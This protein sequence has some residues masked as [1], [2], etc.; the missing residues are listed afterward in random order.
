VSLIKYAAANKREAHRLLADVD[1]LGKKF[2]VPERRLWHIKVKAFAENGEWANLRSL[3]ESKTK[4]PIGFRP[5][6]RAAIKGKLG[7]AEVTRYIE[8]V[9]VPEE[10]YDLF[11]EAELWK[12]ALDEAVKMR[13]AQ[14]VANVRSLCNSEEEVQELCNKALSRLG[15]A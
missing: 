11:C 4:S 3:G 9:T 8:K 1:K 12:R 6:A 13:D 14:R 5:F 7:V 10:R 2:R 15:A